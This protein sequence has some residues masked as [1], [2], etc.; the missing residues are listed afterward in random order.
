MGSVENYCD[1]LKNHPHGSLL[2]LA[3]LVISNTSSNVFDPKLQCPFMVYLWGKNY[4]YEF[5]ISLIFQPNQKLYVTNLTTNVNFP[6]E[7]PAGKWR[8]D[9]DIFTKDNGKRE[10]LIQMSIYLSIREKKMKLREKRIQ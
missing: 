7:L 2:K 8:A 1:F 5:I 10:M 9:L 6:F 3:E 4:N